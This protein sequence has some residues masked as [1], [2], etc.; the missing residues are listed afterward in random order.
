M[1]PE[2]R[3]Q[4]R[5]SRRL[6]KAYQLF[7]VLTDA[8]DDMPVPPDS[9]ADIRTCAER[10]RVLSRAYLAACDKAIA[11]TARQCESASGKRLVGIQ[12]TLDRLRCAHGDMRRDLDAAFIPKQQ[13]GGDQ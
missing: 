4:R 13:R 7:F 11:A 9:L 10:I 3:H 8:K 5:L 12:A 2:V 1:L 6:G